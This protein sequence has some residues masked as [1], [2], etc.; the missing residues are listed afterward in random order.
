MDA[1]WSEL[2]THGTEVEER[3][4]PEHEFEHLFG[5]ELAPGPVAD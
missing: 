1:F 4:L 5:G 2:Q 3:K